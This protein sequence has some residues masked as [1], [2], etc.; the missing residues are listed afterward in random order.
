MDFITQLSLSNS[1]DSILV[2]VDRFSKMAV[3]IRTMS[4]IT[5]IDL[6]HLFIKNIFSK[7]GLPSSSFSDRGPLFVSSFWTNL[8]QQLNISQDYSTAYHPE[9]DRHTE[10]VNQI[11]EQYLL[12]Y[13]SPFFTVYGRD[14][15]LDSVHITQDTPAGK[16]STK[17]QSV[18]QD[19]KRELENAINR[20]KRYA[21]KSRESPP[22]FNPGDMVWLSSKNIKSTGPTKKLSERCLGPFPTLK[23]VNTHAYHLNGNPSTQSSIFPSWNQSRHQQSQIGIKSLLLQSPLEKKRNR[24]SF[25][26]WIKSSRGENYGIWWNG[27]VSVKTQKDPLGNQPKASRIVLILSKICILCILTSQDPILQK[28]D[29][30]WFLV[31]RGITK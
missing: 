26:Y 9:T 1:F 24:K 4:S 20:F 23:K 22:V 13:Q 15:Q 10:R 5:S 11:L 27:K 6:A 18:Q 31:G 25:K 7:H 17:I 2:I 3:F 29:C 16:L 30:L 28:L 8:C 19:V 21:D 12:M 14:P